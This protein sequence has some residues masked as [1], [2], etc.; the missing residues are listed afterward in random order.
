MANYFDQF[1]VTPAAPVAQGGANYF[2]QFDAPKGVGATLAKAFS[3]FEDSQKKR[4]AKLNDIVN[5]TK[6]GQQTIPE[7]LAQG[8]MNEVGAGGDV[9]GAGVS[10]PVKAAY[11]ALPASAQ[12]PID[13]A[14]QSIGNAVAPIAQAYNQNLDTYNAQNP[15]AGRNLDAIRE[16][17]NLLP[18]LNKGVR[19]AGTSA[20]DA[21]ASA[22]GNVATDS[23]LYAPRGVATVTKGILAKSPEQ[24]QVIEDALKASST[25]DYDALDAANIITNSSGSQKISDT[26]NQYLKDNKVSLNPTTHPN[27]YNVVKGL[28]D[29]INSDVADIKP[30]PDGNVN[31]LSGLQNVGKKGELS[32]S[33]LDQQRKA[34][35]GASF[36]N[37]EDVR[38]ASIVRDAMDTAI[39][40]TTS[41]IMPRDLNNGT[42]ENMGLLQ[43]AQAKW[44]Q[45]SKY[46]DIN[47]LLTKAAGDPNKTK[48]AL[49]NFL[50]KD[51][52][53]K[54]WSEQE[55]NALRNAAQSGIAEK[56]YKMGGKFGL[57]L[58]TSLTPGNT[59]APIIGGALT[60]G[61]MSGAA[62]IAGGTALRQLQ[63]YMAR[64][65]AE[66]LLS[67][68]QNGKI[69]KEIYNLP[70][71]V[72]KN[73]IENAKSGK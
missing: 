49:T 13:S 9:I 53:T 69:P 38:A 17:A 44:A 3:D 57:D 34:L 61:P 11:A 15:R 40:P 62:V 16:G 39:N 37:P 25:N 67:V 26:I 59:V 65:K 35:A 58:G 56:L 47:D 29:I 2:D 22:A 20:I 68:I 55:Y 18:F 14:M 31:T 64:G 6:N 60:G 21:A 42:P 51:K 63:K 5:A 73:I 32:I 30:T 10:A 4:G 24:R 36:S 7:G 54:G 46:E 23:A 19:D 70:A 52:N 43:Q 27:T 71:P 45:K 12:A 8:V 72:A 33:A 50:N 41:K 1:D 66:Q 28:D 48:A